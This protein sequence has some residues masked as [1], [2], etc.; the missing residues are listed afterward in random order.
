MSFTEHE[1]GQVAPQTDPTDVVAPKH[2]HFAVVAVISFLV[3]LAGLIMAIGY[4]KKVTKHNQQVGGPKASALN[5]WL[6]FGISAALAFMAVVAV[7]L[8]LSPR[9]ATYIVVGTG[10]A[11]PS[12]QPSQA[13]PSAPVQGPEAVATN[14]AATGPIQPVASSTKELIGKIE[15]YRSEA[16]LTSDLSTLDKYYPS[17]QDVGWQHDNIVITSGK[18]AG[19]ISSTITGI[20]LVSVSDTK[21]VANVTFADTYTVN[22]ERKTF[23]RTDPNTYEVINGRWFITSMK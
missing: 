12:A 13:A 15:A 2:L 22:G 20:N 7:N 10:P 19:F 14:P 8:S 18:T 5:Y 3:P 23:V 1:V 21:I 11:A 17:R 9:N 16:F 6:V 4:N